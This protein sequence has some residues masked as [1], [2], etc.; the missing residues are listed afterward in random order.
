[1]ADILT[2]RRKPKLVHDGYLFVFHKMDKDEDIKFWRCEAFNKKDVRC[3]AR[4]HSENPH[5]WSYVIWGVVRTNGT[6]F[7]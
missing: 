3:K 7:C 1:M 5:I 4:L 6:C 2:K